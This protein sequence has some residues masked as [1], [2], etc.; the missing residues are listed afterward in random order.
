MLATLRTCGD[1]LAR[2]A[3]ASTGYRSR[4]TECAATALIVAAAPILTPRSAR[5]SI[6]LGN[7]ARRKSTRCCGRAMPAR[8]S[9]ISSVPPMM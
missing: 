9:G 7:P 8:I 6:A 3:R 5:S 2:R 1:A 4:M